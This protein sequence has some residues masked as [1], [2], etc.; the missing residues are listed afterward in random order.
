MSQ[1]Q[2]QLEEGLLANDSLGEGAPRKKI[3]WDM[4]YPVIALCIGVLTQGYLLI[5]CFPYVAFLCIHLVPGLTEQTAGIYAGTLSAVFMV[6]RACSS[7]TWGVIADRFGRKQV[8]Y[9]SYILSISFSLWFGLS[10]AIWQAIVARFL[11]GA[12][13]G[14]V[15]VVKT[16]CTEICDGDKE[17]EGKVMGFVFGMRGWGFLFSP[18]LGGFLSDP[19]KQFP[20][21]YISTHFTEFF[22]TYP[23]ILPNIVAVII[24]LAGLLTTMFWVKETK[25]DEIID[26]DPNITMKSIWSKPATR[27][28]LIAFWVLVFSSLFYDESVPLF[29]VAVKGG[30]GIEEKQIGVILSGAGLFY[31]ALQY[32]LY[33]KIMN[34]FGLYGTMKLA[35]AL[36]TP[37]AMLTPISSYLNAGEPL[38]SINIFTY[39]FLC[40][41]LG[42]IRIFAGIYFATSSLGANRSVSQEEFSAM[43]GLSM[44]GGSVAQ[45]FGPF[46]A[47]CLSSFALSG[48]T[49]D[50]NVGCYLTF[51]V[52]TTFGIGLVFFTFCQLKKHHAN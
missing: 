45:A 17:L 29:F 11:L 7:Y 44:L 43:N 23:Y 34:R 48:N 20:N 5:S 50:P 4:K 46:M 35:A 26:T 49:F 22:T 16:V 31:G 15:A 25:P 39:L 3:L 36:G 10:T 47:G 37:L 32:F 30:L 33:H 24:C 51:S 1:R 38:H 41:L 12:A 27:D 28:H 2:P 9:W 21:S 40:V 6:G 19:V 8:F 18:A 42:T 52:V 13:N 14:L